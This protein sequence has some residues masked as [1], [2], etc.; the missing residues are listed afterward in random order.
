MT[1]QIAEANGDERSLYW[2]LQV[3]IYKSILL[4]YN[5]SQNLDEAS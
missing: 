1:T 2:Y 3:G 4:T 5:H